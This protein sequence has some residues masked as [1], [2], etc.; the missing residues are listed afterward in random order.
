MNIQMNRFLSNPNLV[1][2]YEENN[3][4]HLIKECNNL[5]KTLI[6]KLAIK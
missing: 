2:Y 6:N 1:F 5:H 4:G 3:Q